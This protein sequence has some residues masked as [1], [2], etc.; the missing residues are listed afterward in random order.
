M[1][2]LNSSKTVG[3]VADA[4]MDS[5]IGCEHITVGS[6]IAQELLKL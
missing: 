2:M 4:P 6:L 5:S 1:F 3:V